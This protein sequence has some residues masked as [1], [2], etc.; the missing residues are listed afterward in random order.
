MKRFVFLIFILVIPA[1]FVRPVYAADTLMSPQFFDVLQKQAFFNDAFSATDPAQMTDNQMKNVLVNGVFVGALPQV[2]VIIQTDTGYSVGTGLSGVATGAVAKGIYNVSIN[3]LDG[4]QMLLPQ[5]P[6]DLSGDATA[7]EFIVLMT[8]R[9][10][11]GTVVYEKIPFSFRTIW[12]TVQ[13]FFRTSSTAIVQRFKG[14]QVEQAVAKPTQGFG[15]GSNTVSLIVKLVN[16]VNG[17]KKVDFVDPLVPWANVELTL[18][19]VKK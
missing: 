7:K 10:G 16:D 11:K 6:L 2:G 12:D 15:G 5:N 3:P 18:I 19:P 13:T 8:N 17:N 14:Q 1:F 4:V 9:N